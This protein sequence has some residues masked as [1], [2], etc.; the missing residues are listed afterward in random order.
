MIDCLRFGIN[1]T[2]SWTACIIA[3]SFIIHYTIITITRN[4]SCFAN[5]MKETLAL[6]YGS[7]LPAL[8]NIPSVAK[9]HHRQQQRNI[10]SIMIRQL[11]LLPSPANNNQ[12][13]SW[14][15]RRRLLVLATHCVLTSYL[16]SAVFL[17]QR[18]DVVRVSIYV[19]PTITTRPT[20]TI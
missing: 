18:D 16:A 5:V 9:S 7:L 10:I 19:V 2:P 8:L 13:A 6:I 3:A 20:I 1:T 12:N 15:W 11:S 17:L 14:S 4:C